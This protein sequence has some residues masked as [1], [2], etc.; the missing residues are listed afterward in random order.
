MLRWV[1]G[2]APEHSDW[3]VIEY[4]VNGPGGS[5]PGGDTVRMLELSVGTYL[6]PQDG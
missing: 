5:M 2:E 1:H 6:P 3:Q 4:V